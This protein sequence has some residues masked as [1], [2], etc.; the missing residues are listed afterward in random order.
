[1]SEIIHSN[2][3]LTEHLSNL[4]LVLGVF[5]TLTFVLSLLFKQTGGFFLD[6]ILITTVGIVGNIISSVIIV[7]ISIIYNKNFMHYHFRA[8]FGFLL[9]IL[10]IIL[11]VITGK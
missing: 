1:M 11:T 2:K 7:V 5:S 4:N 6:E 10:P 8:I 9:A 3:P